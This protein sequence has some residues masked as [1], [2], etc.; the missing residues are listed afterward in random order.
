MDIGKNTCSLV[1]LDANGRVVLRRRAKWE[2]LIALAAKLPPCIVA[3]EASCGARHLG[4]I[5]AARWHGCT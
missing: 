5:F 2:T 4:R 3:M 1:G